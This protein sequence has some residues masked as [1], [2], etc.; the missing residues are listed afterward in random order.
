MESSNIPG[1]REN[2]VLNSNTFQRIR[3]MEYSDA[4]TVHGAVNKTG[5]LLMILAFSSATAWMSIS[6]YGDSGLPYLLVILA[7]LTAF[8]VALITSAN[9][10]YSQVTAPL[11][12]FLEGGVL[13]WL[14]AIFDD[15]Y[16]GIAIQ[17]VFLTFGTLFG[18]LIMYRISGFQV[19]AKFR[20]GLL[21]A[22]LAIFMVY[23]LELIFQLFGVDG[24][25]ILQ[26]SGLIGIGFSL[27]VVLIAA[28]NL[29]LDF[30]LIESGARQ[31][32]PKYMEWY[33]AFGLMVTLIW[34]YLEILELLLRLYA[35]SDDD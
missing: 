27:F 25:S 10:D 21:S 34:L 23:V 28:L 11:Y 18:L 13:G 26:R 29:V 16:P 24:L 4:M 7:S 17:A 15:K 35:S 33:C 31:G 6:R 20:S 9:M 1:R 14:S 2:P 3:S 19:T 22:M 12:A 32:A 8:I 5:I 30:D